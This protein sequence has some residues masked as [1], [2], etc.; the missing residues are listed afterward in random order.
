MRTSYTLLLR[1]SWKDF[2]QHS[3]GVYSNE[4][5]IKAAIQWLCLAQDKTTDGGVSAWFS[6][7]NGWQ[8]SYIETTGYIINT[9]LESSQYFKNSE[10]RERA[11]KMADFL[12]TMQDTTGGYRTVV[13]SRAVDSRPTVFNTGQDLLGLTDIYTLTKNKKYL[14]SVTKAADFLTEIQEEDGSWLKYTY[15]SMKHTYHTRVAWGILKVW[16]I[17]KKPKYK[18]AAL[19]NLNWAAQQLQSNGWF[20]QNNLPK[21]NPSVPYTHT[22]AYAIEGFLWSGILLKEK[23]YIQIA[24]KSALP[25]AKIF[26]QSG[27]LAGTYDSNWKSNNTYTCLT[28]DAQ[29]ALIWLELYKLTKFS[30]FKQAGYKMLRYLK[31]NQNVLPSTEAE[32]KGA[33]KG[34]NPLYGDLAKN[35][36]YCRLAYLNWSTKFFIDALLS[37]EEIFQLESSHGYS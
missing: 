9:F 10:L 20:K 32:I 8:P 34:S 11:I 4:V 35:E 29:L 12:V 2:I 5:H 28:G 6:L 1:E 17:T 37:Q 13:P 3:N 21:P 25:L 33:L 7:L 26:L 22:I 27:F 16:E 23:R 15:G 18:K 14:N 31:S 19:K 30:I 36:G 24:S